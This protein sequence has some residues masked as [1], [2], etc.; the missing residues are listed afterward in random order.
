MGE[1]Y[2]RA[3]GSSNLAPGGEG[4]TDLDILL[5]A[6]LAARARPE[7]IAALRVQ[8]MIDAQDMRDIYSVVEYYDTEVAQHLSRKGRKQIPK[9]ARRT[10]IVAIVNWMMRTE[11]G[12]CGGTGVVAREGTAGRLTDTCDACHGSGVKPLSR[13]VPHAHARTALWLVD[14]INQSAREALKSMR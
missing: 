14:E 8:R 3:S 4:R 10:L 5:A 6:G 2:A 9:D 7:R 12:Y 13:A 11:C 1:R